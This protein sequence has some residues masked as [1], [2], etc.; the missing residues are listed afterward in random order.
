MQEQ[1]LVTGMIIKTVPIGE[2]D[3]RVVI[4]TK[5]RG[6]ITAFVKGAR[7]P[8][9]RFVASTN[10]FCFGQFKMYEGKTAYNLMDTD[11][12]NY[13]EELRDDFES[14]YYGMY[15]LEIADY[16]TRENN[17]EREMLKLVYQ[18]L[19][20]LASKKL[21][22]RLVRYV[23]ELKSTMVNGEFPGLNPDKTYDESTKYAV[24]YIQESSIERLYTFKVTESVLKELGEFAGWICK[25]CMDYSFKSLPVLS[26]II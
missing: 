24:Y 19:K 16:Y 9:S 21:D 22:N 4:L 18:S 26:S 1:I 11:I 2:F 14:A 20:A 6:K 12:S 17:D 5:E 15:L 8:N 10:L 7:R 13:F 23:F 25:R 3:R